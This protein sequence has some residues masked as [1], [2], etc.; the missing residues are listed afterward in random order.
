MENKDLKSVYDEMHSKGSSSWYGQGEEERELILKMGEPWN[1]Y[2][3][4]EIGCGE[5][6]LTSQI[7]IKGAV[8][9]G[10]DYSEVAIKKAKEKYVDDLIIFSSADYHTITTKFDRIV[11]Q[12]VLEH[13]DDP[14]KEL[15]WMMDN[16]LTEHGDVI[17]SSP[18][19][20][21]PRGFIWMALDMVGAVMSKTDLHYLNPSEFMEFSDTNNYGYDVEYCDWGWGN[22]SQMVDDL[23]ERIP[24]ALKDGN[25]IYS[26]YKLY[27][28]IKWI[29]NLPLFFLSCHREELPTWRS[30]HLLEIASFRLRRNSQ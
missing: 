30:H 2:D 6:I 24:K 20:W 11:M 7:A 8:V 16:L 25:I 3:V 27:K 22:H 19:F 12:G 10:I 29:E 26:Q 9:Y 17:T 5:G 18:C 13:L 4:L 15:K 14:F 23:K 28:F 21:N 1:M